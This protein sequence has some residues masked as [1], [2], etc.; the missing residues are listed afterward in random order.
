MQ[1]FKKIIVKTERRSYPVIIGPNSFQLLSKQIAKQNLNRNIFV[2]VDENVKKH[3]LQK[4]QKN[5]KSNFPKKEI[6]TLK[7]GESSKSSSELGRIY[8]D[9]IRKKYGRDTLILAIGGGVTGDISGFVA[10]TYMR[11]VQLIHVPTTLLAD[12]DSSIGGKTGINFN[13]KKNIIGT[14]YQP[15]FVLIDIDFLQTI[16]N[17]EFISGLGEVVKYAFI[18]NVKFYNF[19]F[20]NLEKIHLKNKPVL[21]EIVYESILFKSSVV[22]LD[23]KESGLRKI[24]NLGHTFAHAY[25]SALDFK[26][27]HGE[28]VITGIISALYLSYIK[29]YISEKRLNEFLA[30]LRLIRLPIILRKLDDQKVLNFMRTDK[31]NRGDKI[32]FVL[33]RNIGEIITDV[34]SNNKEIIKSILLMKF[35]LNK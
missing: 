29:G 18:T 10:S 25:E 34:E 7:K 16:S 21:E 4:I 14:F 23:E 2:I 30:N 26:I 13:K 1:K 31:K 33:L 6:Y 20:D 3:F 19:I 32:K 5:L 9:L 12:V 22:A 24:L 27:K 28:A 17:A 15:E 35:F 11:G 8:E